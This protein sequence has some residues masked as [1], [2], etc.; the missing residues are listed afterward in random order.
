MIHVQYV[1][2]GVYMAGDFMKDWG[3]EQGG[4]SPVKKKQLLVH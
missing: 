3:V 1:C 2:A 4:Q